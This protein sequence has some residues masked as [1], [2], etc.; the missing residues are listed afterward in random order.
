MKKYELIKDES[1]DWNGRRLYRIRALR[2]IP[3]VG[4]GEG[5]KGGYIGKEDNLS[6]KGNA[7]VG[8][9]ARVYDNAWIGGNA[10]VY[11]NAW[12]GGNA[13]VYDNAHVHGNAWIYGDAHVRGNAWVDGNAWVYGEARVGGNARVSNT[14]Y[15]GSGFLYK[16]EP[17]NRLEK[18]RYHLA[19]QLG[20][21][22]I[23]DYVILYKRV[24]KMGN[25]TYCSNYDVMFTYKIGEWAEEKDPDMSNESCARGI[26]LSTPLYWE[27]GDAL[28][29]CKVMLEDIIT[30]QEGKVRCKKCLPVKEIKMFSSKEEDK[31][32]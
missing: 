8:S 31:N 4:V 13:W 10:Q 16:K 7:W 5:D 3:D 27:R 14:V 25:N 19:V 30:V 15:V 12:V 26:H 2:D 21:Y 18:I 24:C 22:P 11:D 1:I 23:E 32:V 28:I 20:I 29:A 9:N 6:H 17:K